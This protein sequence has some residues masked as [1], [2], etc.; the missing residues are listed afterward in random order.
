MESILSHNINKWSRSKLS[1]LIKG[2]MSDPP[3]C[4]GL[5]EVK[6]LACPSLPGYNS[7]SMLTKPVHGVATLV[8][9]DVKVESLC[10]MHNIIICKVTCANDIFIHV[11]LYNPWSER[12]NWP[13]LFSVFERFD[14]SKT[15]I[16]GDFNFTENDLEYEK[17]CLF[18]SS[19]DIIPCQG[20]SG[21]TCRG[22]TKPDL[23]FVNKDLVARF[24]ICNQID[25]SDHLPLLI[26]FNLNTSVHNSIFDQPVIAVSRC[27]KNILIKII[28]SV[29]IF[30][31][32]RIA[33][34][35]NDFFLALEVA[36]L[37]ELCLR[38]L[39][40]FKESRPVLMRK[41]ACQ[42][43]KRILCNAVR[44]SDRLK[45]VKILTS[46]N[47]S[48]FSFKEVAKALGKA[49]E[50]FC[51]P[52]LVPHV[53]SPRIRC[54]LDFSA[55]E[56]KERIGSLDVKKSTG[57]SCINA[58]LLKLTPHSWHVI[59]ANRFN[60]ISVSEYPIFFRVRKLVGVPKSDGSP[61]PIAILS[62]LAK[63]YDAGLADRLQTASSHLLPPSQTAYQKNVRGC[64]ENI[65]I[66]K[67]VCQKYPDVIMLFSDFSKAFNSMPNKIIEKSLDQ[68]GISD[69]LIAAVLDSIEYYAVADVV[70]GEFLGLVRGQPQGACQSG[71]IFLL[72]IRL[73]SLELDQFPKIKPLFLGNRP[74]SHGG[75]ADDCVGLTRCLRDAF[76]F[77]RILIS[78][79]V[80][81]GMPLN[82]S[83]CKYISNGQYIL[84]FK[85]T[86]SYKYLGV[87][88]SLSKSG[89]FDFTRPFNTNTII[90]CKIS[91]TIFHIPTPDSLCDIIRSFNMGPFGLHICYSE[92][93]RTSSTIGDVTLF[94]N[95]FDSHWIQIL[96]KFC[97]I[98]GNS[99]IISI[100]RISAEF[101]L[102]YYRCGPAIVRFAADFVDY[103]LQRPADSYVRLAFD[104]NLDCSLDLKFA[105]YF[106]LKKAQKI[107][108]P[109]ISKN[110]WGFCRKYLRTLVG[111]IFLSVDSCKNS[112]IDHLRILISQKKYCEATCLAESMS[113]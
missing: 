4:I 75:F 79:S 68:L 18:F 82:L 46:N 13:E 102:G 29:D 110:H 65:F 20:E 95:R 61:R 97:N 105:K 99:T 39:I 56:V 77:C 25:N 66:V 32:D 8:R 41:F 63:L 10:C 72:C 60:L 27:H 86:N 12:F 107:P 17:I 31:I 113:S 50:G 45:Y 96:K 37:H 3:I 67:S 84:P 21:F 88:I 112:K 57:I 101:C 55:A 89:R 69:S 36:I 7:L 30:A 38:G 16:S 49:E 87:T 83:K 19:F 24:V 52:Q 35:N 43:I 76:V 42:D 15:I 2:C 40:K 85:R 78:W 109:K 98:D 111:P 23:V 58:R 44:R 73:L 28:D 53:F 91:D 80:R 51:L 14:V 6:R 71:F 74:I 106:L 26:K 108:R 1:A 54:S 62:A 100:N 104:E 59:L 81:S 90:T 94:F 70:S 92:I 93:F 22:S 103:V 33:N 5:Q 64:E 9:D 11:N 47:S 34:N 48:G